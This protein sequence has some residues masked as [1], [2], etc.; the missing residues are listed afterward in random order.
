[1]GGLGKMLACVSDGYHMNFMVAGS[2]LYLDLALQGGYLSPS[3]LPPPYTLQ[4]TLLIQVILLRPHLS[5]PLY[6]LQTTLLI[7]I[8]F[9]TLIL[10]LLLNHPAVSHGP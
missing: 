10:D 5:R 9:Y 8:I 4:T 1:M 6:M 2:L 3:S 7:Q